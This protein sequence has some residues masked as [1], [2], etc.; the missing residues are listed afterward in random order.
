[1]KAKQHVEDRKK[2]DLAVALRVLD[3]EERRL[4]DLFLAATNG[5]A[6]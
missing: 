6:A 3:R 4:E 1:M 5:E 2:E